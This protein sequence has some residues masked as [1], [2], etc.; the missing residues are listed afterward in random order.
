MRVLV[1]EATKSRIRVAKRLAWQMPSG[2]PVS[3]SPGGLTPSAGGVPRC[4]RAAQPPWAALKVWRQPPAHAQTRLRVTRLLPAPAAF[5]WGPRKG[6]PP[7]TMPRCQT[8]PQTGC[9]YS[10]RDPCEGL[11]R[12][13]PHPHLFRCQIPSGATN[14]GRTGAANNRSLCRAQNG[15]RSGATASNFGF[16]RRV[17]WGCLHS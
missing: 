1:G 4:S 11:S 5:P 10:A 2:P 12:Q 17:P 15:K 14:L 9:V 3:A 7:A 8:Q 13:P 6:P 16:P